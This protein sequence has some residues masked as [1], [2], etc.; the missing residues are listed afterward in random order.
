MWLMQQQNYYQQVN[1]SATVIIADNWLL[2]LMI[3]TVHGV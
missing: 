3:N 1:M 2:D